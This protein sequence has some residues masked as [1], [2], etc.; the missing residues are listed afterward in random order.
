MA[1]Q[2]SSAARGLILM[3]GWVVRTVGG[4]AWPRPSSKQGEGEPRSGRGEQ[5]R[6]S[7]GA[8][9]VAAKQGGA[10]LGKDDHVS[11]GLARCNV[12]RD[13]QSSLENVLT[14][15]DFNRDKLES[16]LDV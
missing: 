8:A 11:P 10:N 12:R 1:L 14:R 4:P 2:V 13:V 16:C 6:R 9:Q 5:A 3:P 15:K 7:R